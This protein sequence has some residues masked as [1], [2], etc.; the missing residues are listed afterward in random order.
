M[1]PVDP[2]LKLDKDL[3]GQV[4]DRTYYKQSVGSWMCLTTT[5]P[6]IMNV[7]NFISRYIDNPKQSHLLAAKRILSYLQGIMGLCKMEGSPL[8]MGF[9]NSYCARDR[10]GRKSSIGFLFYVG[11]KC[12]FMSSKK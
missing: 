4:V 5:Q 12:H 10:D 2:S 8:M 7:V 9:T 11:I 3:D 6:D 1:S